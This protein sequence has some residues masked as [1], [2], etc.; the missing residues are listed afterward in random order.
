MTALEDFPIDPFDDWRDFAQ[1][2]GSATLFFAKKSERPQ[3][4]ERREARALRLC[5]A[6]PVQLI[7]RDFARDHR[8]FGFWGGES[9]EDRQLAGDGLSSQLTRPTSP[10]TARPTSPPAAGPTSPLGVRTHTAVDASATAC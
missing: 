1:C 7:C 5:R 3:A 9:E 10:P 2:R 4:R 6:C 8:E